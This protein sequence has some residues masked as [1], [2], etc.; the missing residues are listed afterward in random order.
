MEGATGKPPC[1]WLEVVAVLSK[2]ILFKYKGPKRND[3]IRDITRDLT[4]PEYKDV[5]KLCRGP[6]KWRLPQDCTIKDVVSAILS[7]PDIQLSTEQKNIVTSLITP[8]PETKEPKEPEEKPK[9]KDSSNDVKE[10]KSRSSKDAADE[11][12]DGEVET[13]EDG[14]GDGDSEAGKSTKSMGKPKEEGSED[15]GEYRLL[16]VDEIKSLDEY[17]DDDIEYKKTN[18]KNRRGGKKARHPDIEIEDSDSS[19]IAPPVPLSPRHKGGR[20][21]NDR[22]R[23][24]AQFVRRLAKWNAKQ[25]LTTP[26]VSTV[27]SSTATIS[28]D[29]VSTP[30]ASDVKGESSGM[31][32]EAGKKVQGGRRFNLEGY[33]MSTDDTFLIKGVYK[34]AHNKLMGRFGIVGD[35][36]ANDTIRGLKT[37]NT[38]MVHL[39]LYTRQTNTPDYRSWDCETS[40][41]KLT[42]KN[43]KFLFGICGDLND[44]AFSGFKA[45]DTQRN[46]TSLRKRHG[47]DGDDGDSKDGGKKMRM[48]L[49]SEL[50]FDE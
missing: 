25:G 27:K 34:D 46:D 1:T 22:K 4:K 10:N 5:M 43:M 13:E 12:E 37:S 45:F 8:E 50:D 47:Q 7:L 19:P 30:K 18:V 17:A 6:T 16:T 29:N 3:Y 32:K 40:V 41:E 15:D 36:A 48:A 42:K 9:T 21:T 24:E 49:T 31:A 2:Y 35:K 11:D 44:N 33:D 26:T 38:C 28:T 14:N 20:K 39:V 23:R